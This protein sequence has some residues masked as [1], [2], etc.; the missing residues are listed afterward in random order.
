MGTRRPGRRTVLLLSAL[1]ATGIVAG[2]PATQ[3]GTAKFGPPAKMLSA[4]KGS[5]LARSQG[6]SEGD[7]GGGESDEIL[8][9]AAL[10]SAITT[11][12]GTGVSAAALRSA[13]RSAASIATAGGSWRVA[14]VSS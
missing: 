2:A 8:A 9:R 3:A 5:D 10:E 11:A 14:G 12:P 7:E 6:Q 13:S 1:L 4:L